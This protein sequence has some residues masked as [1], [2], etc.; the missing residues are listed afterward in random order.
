MRRIAVVAVA[1]TLATA[2]TFLLGPGGRAAALPGPLSTGHAHLEGRCE[3]CHVAGPGAIQSVFQGITVSALALE[4]NQLCVEC[5]SPGA[6]PTAPHSWS[7]TSLASAKNAHGPDSAGEPRSVSRAMTSGIPTGPSGELACA[8]CHREHR[9]R[10]TALNELSDRQCQACH[11]EPF[12]GFEDGHPDFELRPL[13]NTRSVIFDH[14]SH[15]SKHFPERSSEDEAVDPP[16]LCTDCHAPDARG[17][18]MELR[19]FEQICGDCHAAEIHGDARVA[20]GLAVFG[21][22]ALD[23]LTLEDAKIDIGAWAADSAISESE[24]T[25]FMEL[26]LSEERQIQD[27]LELFGAL[28]LLDLTE[29][30]EEE[31]AAVG[32]VARAIQRV[33]GDLAVGGHATLERRLRSVSVTPR[34]QNMSAL[35]GGLGIDTVRAAM[36]AWSLGQENSGADAGTPEDDPEREAWSGDGG[37]FR[38]DADFTLRYRPTG[39]GDRFLRAWLDL[40]AAATASPAGSHAVEPATRRALD[41]IFAALSDEN[42]VGL[43]TK[44]HVV[45]HGTDGPRRVRWETAPEAVPGLGLTHFSHSSHFAAIEDEGCHTCHEPADTERPGPAADFHSIRPATCNTCHTSKGSAVRCLTCHAYH[46]RSTPRALPNTP[47][48]KRS[49]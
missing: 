22:P 16:S 20:N 11:S 10:H 31:Q 4:Q 23:T 26:L 7:E 19:S 13:E 41:A 25:P 33:L 14:A 45:E 17:A 21:L 48:I 47:L 9:G 18:G 27:A 40:S 49:R 35:V 39:H 43:C 12:A 24:L 46:E 38:Q 15:F 3:V 28:D 30:T 42:A 29:S 2:M 1:C 6:R 34:D 36:G 32:Q 44:C 5:H 8:T 37:W